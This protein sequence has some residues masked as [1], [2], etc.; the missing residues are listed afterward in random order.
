[1]ELNR[2]YNTDCIKGMEQVDNES[3]DL[4]LTD[5]PYN[6]TRDSNFS[7]MGRTGVDF[8]DW[9]RGFNQEDWLKVA[10]N[11]VKTGGSAI[12]FNDYKNIGIMTKVLEENGFTIKEL[13]VWKKP[14]PMPRNTDRLYVTS[15]E[16]AIWAIKGKGWTFNKQRDSYEDG[17]FVFPTVHSGE[18][19]HP[20][21]KP[22]ALIETLLKIHS[23]K[24]DVVLD[25]FMGSATTA[26]ACENLKRQYI[27]F[28][29]DSN[30]YKKADKRL[31][32]AKRKPKGLFV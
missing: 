25:C 23:N 31:N 28:E 16:I 12:I 4:L 7:S 29:L 32:R 24:D 8:G 27:G 9:D 21:Q 10:C 5:P 17:V 20:T 14:N 30:M 13:L 2:I 22:I 11:K 1:M 3:I 15:V 6:V 19:V 18:R 26:I